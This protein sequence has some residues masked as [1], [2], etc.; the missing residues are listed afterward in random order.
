MWLLRGNICQLFFNIIGNNVYEKSYIAEF[1]NENTIFPYH[2]SV[3]ST[4]FLSGNI[5]EDFVQTWYDIDSFPKI[6]VIFKQIWQHTMKQIVMINIITICFIV[7]CHRLL[8]YSRLG[9][10]NITPP[11]FS[12]CTKLGRWAAVYLC[13]RSIDFAYFYD[14]DIDFGNVPTDNVVFLFFYHFK[15][16]FGLTSWYL[17]C[18]LVV[19]SFHLI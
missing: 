8:F 10:T 18:M 9:Q 16:R 13:V 3:V 5:F 19:L 6:N 2:A 14:F 15:T 4:Y 12:A 1:Y 11:L 7:C 17:L